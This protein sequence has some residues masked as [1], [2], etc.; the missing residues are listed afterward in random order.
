MN[1]RRERDWRSNYNDR[2]R[3]Q[4]DDDRRACEDQY[5]GRAEHEHRFS[6]ERD[7]DRY[8]QRAGGHQ[9]QGYERDWQRSRDPR[10]Y[11]ASAAGREW[12]RGWDQPGR[13]EREYGGRGQWSWERAQ[14]GGE[15]PSYGQFGGS[16]MGAGVVSSGAGWNQRGD[17]GPSYGGRGYGSEPSWYGPNGSARASYGTYGAEN[18]ARG[19]ERG[20]GHYGRGPKGY[21][22]S[23]DRIREDVCDRLS[24]DDEVDASDITV[25]V[26]DGEVTLEGTVTDRY[27]KHRAEDIAD[28]VHGVR[29]VHNR[30][31]AKKGFVQEV[32]ERLLGR[33]EEH[34]G[35]H[36]G[37]GTRNNPNGLSASMPSNQVRNGA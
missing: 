20:S 2:P 19:F 27:S 4:H 11:G 23:D 37:S 8:R 18:R 1:D 3:W 26:K 6:E 36:S 16:G 12:E 14:Y 17:S 7:E 32:G 31:K 9:H 5:I 28:A 35:G 13:A 29:D 33:E 10:E 30:L 15:H 25:N 21:T 24:Y 34:D 22:R